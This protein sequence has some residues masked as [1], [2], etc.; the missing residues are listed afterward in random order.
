MPAREEKLEQLESRMAA[1]SFWNDQTA[2]RVLIDEAN[3]L[4]A[5]V[6]PW[7]RLSTKVA[8]LGEM[9]DLLEVED[10]PALLSEV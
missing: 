6:E 4:K 2:A 10:D 8:D 9:L 5:W 1:P 7:N 3:K